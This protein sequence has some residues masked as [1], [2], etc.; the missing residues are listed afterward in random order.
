MLLVPL[1]ILME[2]TGKLKI[3]SIGIIQDFSSSFG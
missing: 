3:V 1:N 2:A